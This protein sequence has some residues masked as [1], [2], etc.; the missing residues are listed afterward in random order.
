MS[1][2]IS[3]LCFENLFDLFARILNA[4]R[5]RLPEFLSN[6]S[7][8]N[9]VYFWWLCPNLNLLNSAKCPVRDLNLFNPKAACLS[10]QIRCEILSSSMEPD[11]DRFGPF[12][13]TLQ[14][15]PLISGPGYNSQWNKTSL[16]NLYSK[17]LS[18]CN[19][20]KILSDPSYALKVFC[21]CC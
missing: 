21:L 1:G 14:R 13:P 11:P 3:S 15:E 5:L 20:C 9:W 7:S 6:G 12:W 18:G 10:L 19:W 2:S 16:S 8:M 4:P 17:T